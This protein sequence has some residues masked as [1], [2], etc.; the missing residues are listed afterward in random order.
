MEIRAVYRVGFWSSLTA[1][2]MVAGF[3]LSLIIGLLLPSYAADAMS[4]VTCLI[5]PASFVAMM[6]SIHHITPAEKRV[7]SQLGLSFSII[8]AVMCSI[9]YYI[10]LVVVRTNSLRISPDV[11]ALLT[12]TPGSAM[13]AVD[14]LG[15]AFLTLATLVTSPVFGDSLR[16]KWLKRLFFIHGL[17]A[18]PTIV[19]PAFRF[20]QES[21]AVESANQGG[22]FALLFWC[23]LFLPISTILAVHFRR[24]QDKAVPEALRLSMP[25]A[26]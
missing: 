21:A 8:Y 23:L 10:Q 5:L 4:Y 18:L 9:V 24:L 20:S 14:M 26:A 19:F 3:A 17:F 6:V 22:A 13:F 12:F 2:A 15:Y 11:M 7:W 1:T 16:E 25:T